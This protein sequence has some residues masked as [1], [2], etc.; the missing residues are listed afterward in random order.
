MSG[1]VKDKSMW[2]EMF[3]LFM[4]YMV[5]FPEVHVCFNEGNFKNLIKLLLL[6]LGSR[7]SH[8]S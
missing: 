7:S 3:E 5:N 4:V 6:Y 2:Y 8:T 1:N